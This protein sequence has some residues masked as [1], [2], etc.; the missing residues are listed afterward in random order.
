M[1]YKDV[2]IE[3]QEKYAA[4][5]RK[6]VPHLNINPSLIEIA[7]HGLS[8]GDAGQDFLDCGLGL[9][10]REIYK[11][12]IGNT[13]VGFT[14][15]LLAWLPGQFMPEHRHRDILAVP[16]KADLGKF[17]ARFVRLESLV[18]DFS[19]LV[20]FDN[21]AYNFFTYAEDG[22]TFDN[23]NLPHGFII[24]PGKAETFDIIYGDGSFFSSGK[25]T[26]N[27]QYHVPVSQ[28]PYIRNGHEIYL[29]A[30]QQLH[31]PPNTPHS[32]RAGPNGMVAIEYSM[33]S[34]DE[35]DI[36]TDP[37][38]KRKIEIKERSKTQ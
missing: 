18:S 38:I 24:I 14:G 23:L 32:A 20:G 19:G 27:P 16:K 33:P 15:K 21:D 26:E 30:G 7:D 12:D 35:A 13:L 2:V 28:M 6:A 17:N 34:R 1:L 4:L 25:E 36:F 9:L 29:T 11:R 22:L 31:L 3:L 37:R 10:V 8:N 5:F